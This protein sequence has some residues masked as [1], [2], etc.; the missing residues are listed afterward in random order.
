[1][2]TKKIFGYGTRNLFFAIAVILALAFTACDNGI[3][4]GGNN[5]G[6]IPSAL[7]GKWYTQAG[8]LAFEITSAGLFFFEEQLYDVS[9]SG[10]TVVLKQGGTTVGAFDY[11]INN[12]EMTITNGM[13]VGQT[14]ALLSPVVKA[15]SPSGGLPPA[16]VG[17]WYTQAN[18]LAFEITSAGKILIASQSFDIAV[19]GKTVTL[20][21]SGTAV[22]TF[23]YTISNNTMTITNG[24]M[25]GMT[26]ALLSPVVKVSGSNPSGGPPPALVGMWYTQANDPAFEITS[27]G[28]I[29]VASQSFDISVSGKTVTL[30]QSGAAVGTFDYAI[31]NNTMTITNGTMVGMTI[32]LLSPVVKV[33]GS[34][35]S[36]GPPPALV[37]MWYTQANDPAFEITSAGKILLASQSFDISVSGNTVTLKQSGTAVGTFD[38][39]INNN[40]M[41]ITNGTMVGMTV[42]LLSPVVKGGG[43]PPNPSDI[44]VTG[45]SLNST[46][47]TMNVGQTATLTATV[48]PSNATN[49][50]V[51]WSVSPGTTSITVA[52][53]VVSA[54]AA[55]TATV[56]VTTVDGGKVASCYVTVSA[57]GNPITPST[58]T[59]TFDANGGNGWGPNPITVNAGSSITLPSESGLS[60]PDYAFG[61]WNTDK[62]GWGESYNAG[63]WYTVYGNITLYAMWIQGNE[64]IEIIEV[65][66]DPN[67]GYGWVD[68]IR[69]NAGFGSIITLP[70]ENGIYRDG[71]TFGG[72]TDSS[73]TTY[74]AGSSFTPDNYYGN[75]ITLYAVWNEN[76]TGTYTVTFDANGGYGD[77]NPITV[78][79]GSTITLPSGSGFYQTGYTFGGWNTNSSGTGTNYSAGS[80]YTINSSVTF[81]AMWI[82]GAVPTNPD[83]YSIT[84]A[85]SGTDTIY[86]TTPLNALTTNLTVIAQY[87]DG[88]SKTLASTD[89][90]LSGVLTAG[91]SA[92]T[93]TYEG[94][95]ST[96][97][98]MVSDAPQGNITQICLTPESIA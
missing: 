95:T 62:D 57:G 88:T 66:F 19:S 48:M 67:G 77:S 8:D 54:N 22:G 75:Y 87:N 41:T 93:V 13:M 60:S 14:V 76:Q 65:S 27:A 26:V 32:A 44:P 42:A 68:P 34:N 2:N 78:S 79:A 28:K 59:V 83:L 56:I 53:G 72:W 96:F 20:K 21:Q 85:Y 45:V 10:K 46:T 89:Y 35:P 69:V 3:G 80:T 4:G 74:A 58:Y 11:A 18:D 90:T 31:N 7:A 16:L 17:M 5:D 84:V 9:V 55:G 52:N 86:P 33:S 49:K 94:K 15:G 1:M 29:L 38:Y 43:D 30:K 70:G 36:G 91:T 23:D 25:V 92:V 12:N 97:T 71:Y 82:D 63:D 61:G 73:G 40:T 64:Q 47:L 39:A 50:A 24:T 81:Y 6:G 51:T 98:V 37:G